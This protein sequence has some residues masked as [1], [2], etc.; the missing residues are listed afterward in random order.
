MATYPVASGDKDGTFGDGS[1]TDGVGL[2]AKYVYSL[3]DPPPNSGGYAYIDTS[4]IGTDTISAATL[5]W[6]HSAYSKSKA[7]AFSRIIQVGTE[8]VLNSS[9]TP[10]VGWA[11]QVLNSTAIAQINKTGET[12]ISFG[13]DDPNPYD[14]TW[15]VRAWDYDSG[16]S[17]CYLDVT[18]APA[19]GGPTRFSI[20][21]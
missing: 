21:R 7:A 20:L 12:L 18:H 11:S 1:N 3:G 9:A 17:A 6:Y 5:Y 10:S 14:R 8:V 15:S 13:V 2:V 16:T 4:A 19:A